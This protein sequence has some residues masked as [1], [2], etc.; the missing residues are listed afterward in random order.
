[1]PDWK[2]EIAKRLRPLRMAPP[3]EAEIIE[4]LSQ[5]LEDRYQELLASGPTEAEARR[6]VLE[7]LHPLL[8]SQTN[9]SSGSGAS[10]AQALRSVEPE[11]AANPVVPGGG[12]PANFFSSLW[13]DLRF[14]LR[15]LR[16]SPAFTAVAILTLALGIGANTAIF[17]I[18]NAVLLRPLPFKD[19]ARL[20]LLHEGLPKIGFPKMSFS[21]PD[22]AVFAREQRLFSEL[23]FFLNERMDISGQGEP[24]RVTVTRVSANLL[25]MLG[26]EPMLGRAFAPEED[27]P[28]HP[29][30][31]L[32]Y[33]L[34][35]SRY[36]GNPKIL[37]QQI[38][39]D[40]RPYVVIGVMPRRFVFPL[41]GLGNNGSPAGLWV[42]RAVTP[43]ELRDWGG[44][45]LTSVVARLPVGVTLNQTQA[46]LDSLAPTILAN[47]PAEIRNAIPGLTLDISASPFHEEAVGSVRARLLL[48][49][50]AVAFV[51]LIACAN[52]ATL[53]LSRAASR[54]KEIAVRT[55]LGA[56]RAR[57]ARQMLTEGFL[58]AFAGGAFGLL[59]SLWVINLLPAI[60]PST[61]ALPVH[62]AFSGNV[63]TFAL[64]AS[65]LVAVLF[66][67]APALQV[68]SLRLQTPLQESGRAATAGCSR[69]RA[70]QFFVTAEFALAL[71]L[72]VGAGLLIRSFAKLLATSPGFRPDHLLTLNVPLPRQAYSRASQLREFY[73]QLLAKASAL[74]GVESAT[75]STDLPLRATEMVS[76]GVEGKG[77]GLKATCQTW[78]MGNYFQALGVPLTRGRW[79]G[80]EDRPGTQPVAVVSAYTART[81]WPDQEAVGKRI[82]WGGGPWETVIGI[83]ADVKQSSLGAPFVPHIYRPYRQADDGLVEDDPFGDWHAMNLVL[84]TKTDPLSLTSAAIAQVRSLDPQLAVANIRTMTEVIS[85][86][87]AGPKFNTFLLGAFAGAALLLAAIGIYGVLAYS[88]SQRTHEIGVR[89]ALG[90]QRAGVMRL[91]LTEG[92]RLALLGTGIG[93]VAALFLMRLMSSLLYGV[94]PLDPLTF[95]AVAVVLTAAALAAC[96]IPARRATRVDPMVALRYE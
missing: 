62:V 31:I 36:G 68:S 77:K 17:S 54:Q 10:L 66:G 55:A 52:I 86:S 27:A 82:R 80:P 19:S 28:G 47:Y 30:A 61:T 63:F 43:V 14:A 40:R 8:A 91:I 44:L 49:M 50:A 90:A 18:V 42:P 87:V 74:P 38:E 81:L 48:L 32:S 15:I 20:V 60:L 76:F 70:Q 7:E 72:L 23:G 35:Q 94:S 89:M 69:H 39:L 21:P 16:K 13:Q 1:M 12:G 24:D 85:S 45:Y 84:R 41:P 9:P 46:Q 71:V 26:A 78:V 92:T 34:W 37:G 75:I 95:I 56:T 25:P 4:E 88:V 5:H 64:A 79:F 33:A 57:L 53:L 58:L 3:R 59:L 11:V 96:Y 2:P 51:L 65:I 93:T 29:V 67:L 6:S 22:L 83:V 73:E